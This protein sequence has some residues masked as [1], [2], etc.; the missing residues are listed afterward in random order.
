MRKL[1]QP[2]A[3]TLLAAPAVAS[4][5]GE[6]GGQPG[7]QASEEAEQEQQLLAALLE[8]YEWPDRHPGGFMCEAFGWPLAL[9]WLAFES[10]H[11][12]SRVSTTAAVT[13]AR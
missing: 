5:A 13:S 12:M 2:L 6:P 8:I 10:I 4:V 11:W 1:F 9:V 3:T 7:E